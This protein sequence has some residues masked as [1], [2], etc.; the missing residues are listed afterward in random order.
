[1]VH[2]NTVIAFVH[3]TIHGLIYNA[4]K[5]F[6]EI[7]QKLFDEC[8]QNY[9][10]QRQKEKEFHNKRDTVWMKIEELA[11]ANPYYNKI[12]RN[13][14]DSFSSQTGDDANDEIMAYDR[15]EAPVQEV[16][17]TNSMA[18]TGMPRRCGIPVS[19]ASTS[20]ADRT[21]RFMN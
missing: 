17:T 18:G 12:P 20:N 9:K 3:R 8:T 21:K 13:R 16:C 14:D 1:M 10:L 4:L 7:N 2:Y 5:L 19:A 15:F 6:M 11:S